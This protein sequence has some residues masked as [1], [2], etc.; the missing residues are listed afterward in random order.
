VVTCRGRGGGGGANGGGGGGGGG[1][2]GGVKVAATPTAGLDAHPWCLFLCD[3]FATLSKNSEET[4]EHRGT[5]DCLAPTLWLVAEK[6]ARLIALLVFFLNF[7]FFKFILFQW[8]HSISNCKYF[9][10]D[11]RI[12]NVRLKNKKC[13]KHLYEKKTFWEC[14][15]RDSEKV[16]KQSFYWPDYP[17]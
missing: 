11:R 4:A 1:R 13:L 15:K 17:I 9:A 8:L 14:G 10:N 2:R 6:S 7:C 12:F 3:P 5:P 16:L